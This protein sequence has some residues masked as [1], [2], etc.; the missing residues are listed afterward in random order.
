MDRLAGQYHTWVGPRG[1]GECG[2]AYTT[3]EL[4]SVFLLFL[5]LYSG[6]I[7]LLDQYECSLLLSFRHR[8]PVVDARQCAIRVDL[9]R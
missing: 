5:S 4:L 2:V 6:F 9:R 1:Y 3:N 7:S 8:M